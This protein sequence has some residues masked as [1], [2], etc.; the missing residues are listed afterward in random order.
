MSEPQQLLAVYRDYLA[1]LNARRW[2]DLGR[3]VAQDVRYND[4]PVGL[5]GY[6]AMLEADVDNIPDL[7]FVPEI[8]LAD[9]EV[10]SCRL[11]FRCTPRRAIF[12]VEPTGAPVTFAEHVFYR[13]VDARIVDVRSL[14]DAQAVR[15]QLSV[16]PA[17]AAAP[18]PP[19]R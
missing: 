18:P 12:G 9:G 7:R 3:F 2:D 8:L 1:C 16:P 19:T 11:V 6:R 14:I 10:V 4:E 17:G 13:M 15:D 5:A